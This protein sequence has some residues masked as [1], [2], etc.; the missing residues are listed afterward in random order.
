MPKRLLLSITLAATSAAAQQ[1]TATDRAHAAAAV[2]AGAKYNYAWWDHVRADWD[3]ALGATLR[4]ANEPQ[5]DVRFYR[6]LRRVVALLNDGEARVT[7]PPALAGRLARPPIPLRPLGRRP[8]IVGDAA[9]PEL[10][11]AR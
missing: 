11:I 2:W 3:S 10:R 9:T 6:R 4:A 7:P 8:V 5:S 1:L